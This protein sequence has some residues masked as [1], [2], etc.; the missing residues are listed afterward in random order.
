MSVAAEY[1]QLFD[2]YSKKYGTKTAVLFQIGSFFE[3]LGIDNEKEKRGN[4]VELSSILNMVLTR[5][6]KK[7]AENSLSN[8]LML[9]FPCVA[10]QKY[11][12][13]LLEENYTIVVVEQVKTNLSIRRVVADVISP[14]TYIDGQDDDNFCV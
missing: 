4:A 9:G 12:P 10:L 1:L 2:E 13:V 3:V 7:I 6:N 5:K 14:S 8:P 11:I